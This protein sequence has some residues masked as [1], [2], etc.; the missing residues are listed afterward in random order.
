MA[1]AVSSSDL[2]NRAGYDAIAAR[3]RRSSRAG[4]A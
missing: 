1:Q 2:L 3:W 4:T